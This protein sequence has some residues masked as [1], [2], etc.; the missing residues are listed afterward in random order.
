VDE[1]GIMHV[2]ASVAFQ[3]TSQ[4]LS[5]LN[6]VLVLVEHHVDMDDNARSDLFE[7]SA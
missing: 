3:T 4:Q 7:W 5:R 2:A 1:A 6:G